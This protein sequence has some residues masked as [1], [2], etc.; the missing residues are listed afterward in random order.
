MTTPVNTRWGEWMAPI[1]EIDIDKQTGFPFLLPKQW[2]HERMTPDLT[3]KKALVTGGAPR[4]RAGLR[5]SAGR[6]RGGGDLYRPQRRLD[7]KGAV[8]T[9]PQT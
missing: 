9:A 3:G 2:S 4:N 5:R 7:R 6:R 8:R 1:M